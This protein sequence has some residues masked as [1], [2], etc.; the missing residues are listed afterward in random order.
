MT[1]GTDGLVASVTDPLNQTV[2]YTRNA[3]GQ[4]RTETL[5][6]GHQVQLAYDAASDVTSLTPPGGSAHT[7]TYTLNGDLQ[8][9]QPPAVGSGNTATQDSYNHDQQLTHVSLPDN[10]AV[11]MT[12]DNAGRLHSLTTATG[13]ETLT[14]DPVK[15]VLQSASAT[16]E[17]L[18]FAYDGNLLTGVTWSGD[19][20]GNVSA[21]FDNNFRP[22]SESVNGG[23]TVNFQY[24]NDGLLTS[25]GSLTLNR[26]GPSGRLTGTTLGGVTDVLGYNAFGELISYQASCNG[27]SLLQ[28]SDMHD[29]LGRITERVETIGGV[30]HTYDYGYDPTGQL[31]QV[32]L[33][34]TVTAQYGYDAN[35]NRTTVT[36]P[37]GA[38]S[39]TY[40]IQ[41]RLMSYGST[42]YTYTPAGE[43]QSKTDSAA[44]KTTT[45]SYDALGNLRTVTLPD[46]TLLDYVIDGANR[47]V[48]KKMNGTLVQGWLYD[49]SGRVVAELDGT[50]AVVSR[51]VYAT[52]ANVPDYMIRSGVTYRL[53]TDQVGSVRL[54]VDAAT[55]AV[56]QRIDYDEFGNVLSDTNPGFQPFA[57]AGGLYDSQTGLVRFGARDYDAQTG[58]WTARDP[59]RFGG[60]QA[61]L[62]AFVAGDPL[63]S[64]DPSGLQAA[65]FGPKGDA[66]FVFRAKDGSMWIW[67]DGKPIQ[68]PALPPAQPKQSPK[69]D[70]GNAKKPQMQDP[71]EAAGPQHQ[72]VT[73]LPTREFPDM[74]PSPNPAPEPT[75]EFPDW[76]PAQSPG[77]K[78]INDILD[79]ITQ[80][81]PGAGNLF[82][83]LEDIG[84]FFSKK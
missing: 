60:G 3:L 21:T 32:K 52:G 80:P 48:G 58:R 54:V 62:Y 38:V 78:W 11:D 81:E 50:G 42:T 40:D 33:D 74:I 26:D 14:Y 79:S 7:L 47:R 71:C 19:V 28:Q 84:G 69:K 9:Y 72:D 70:R 22:T 18:A 44:N 20:A 30:S 17:S 61:N 75:R 46:G 57:F 29:D 6:D 36:S 77:E 83:G 55:G 56:A 8:E 25:A 35:G 1:Y 12:Y 53:I 63:N 4:I 31:N 5:P 34:G 39:A 15:G 67:D 49:G 51:F 82:Q 2:R 23:N 27:S 43:L 16:G 13:T 66:P 68:L 45:Y 73:T 37:S 59:I 10:T 65:A 76:Q 64:R 24:D 41:D